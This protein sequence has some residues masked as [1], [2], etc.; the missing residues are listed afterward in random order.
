MHGL[1]GAF[2]GADRPGLLPSSWKGSPQPL[3]EVFGSG[4]A[5]PSTS[6]RLS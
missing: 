4:R 5:P 1:E 2:T 6:R 3:R